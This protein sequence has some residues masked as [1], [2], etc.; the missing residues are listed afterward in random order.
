MKGTIVDQALPQIYYCNAGTILSMERLQVYC[1][2]LLAW[3]RWMKN[4]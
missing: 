4:V 2:H 1:R 3:L